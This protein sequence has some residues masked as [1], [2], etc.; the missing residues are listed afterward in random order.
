MRILIAPG[1]TRVAFEVVRSLKHAKN[2]E[3]IG[4]GSNFQD[5]DS[6]PYSEYHYLPYFNPSS[7]NQL[8]EIASKTNCDFVILTHDE[9][10]FRFAS[11]KQI[12]SARIVI[13][14]E[15]SIQISSFKSLT[16]EF[17]GALVRVPQLYEPDNINLPF[18]LFAKPDRGQ[19]ARN[20]F[21]VHNFAQLESVQRSS[22][23]SLIFCEYLPGHEFTVDCFSDNNYQVIFAACRERKDYSDGI[24][25]NTR[26]VKNPSFVDVWADIFSSKLLIRGAWFF[27]FKL[28]SFGEPVLL[29]LGMR[30][31]G[32]SGISRLRGVNLSLLNLH[33]FSIDS[34]ELKLYNQQ[35]TACSSVDSSF[36]LG[37][38]FK[39]VY[40]DLD[41]TIFVNGEINHKL[42]AFLNGQSQIGVCIYVITR[43]PNPEKMIETHDLLHGI[44]YNVLKVNSEFPKS[45]FIDLN[46]K[47]FLFVDDSHRERWEVKLAFGDSVLVLDPSFCWQGEDNIGL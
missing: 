9:W 16:Y 39:A 36:Q 20:T 23:C 13:S 31:A 11:S 2:I 44:D 41:D 19:G 47:P 30:I 7:E 40:V 37:F 24:S 17:F 32:A 18:P 6:W 25:K 15:K 33:L 1:T 26:H 4:A 35:N 29:E 14:S 3:L 8:A 42:V 12:G 38:D 34:K 43:N 5:S 28:D 22:P 45:H 46:S 21:V 10:L 27:Q